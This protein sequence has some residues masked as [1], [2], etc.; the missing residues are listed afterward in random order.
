M[1][2]VGKVTHRVINSMPK[3]RLVYDFNF[4]ICALYQGVFIS[5]Y[6]LNVLTIVIFS[7]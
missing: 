4:F 3:I 6:R 1:I 7:Y 2:I 5:G